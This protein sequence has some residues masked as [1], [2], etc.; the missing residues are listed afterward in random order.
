VSITKDIEAAHKES[1]KKFAEAEALIKLRELYP[2]LQKRTG[3]WGKVAYYSKAANA[4]AD[5]FD[6]RHNCGC[7]SD[8]PLEIW[9]YVKTPHGNVYSD[10]PCF[11]VGE[12]VP[13]YLE[14]EREDRPYPNWDKGMRDAGI[15]E[16]II[17]IVGH[18]LGA[19]ERHREGSNE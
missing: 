6:M 9:P 18:H 8:S 13:D 19:S 2:D 14:D 16:H 3:R 4:D 17:T 1:A 10:P 12:R 11:T 7:C 15:S 5:D